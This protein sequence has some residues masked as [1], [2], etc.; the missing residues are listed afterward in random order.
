MI[1]EVLVHVIEVARDAEFVGRQLVALVGDVDLRQDRHDQGM[2]PRLYELHLVAG[3]LDPGGSGHDGVQEIG[4][5]L[6]SQRE[7]R[8]VEEEPVAVIREPAADL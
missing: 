6:R 8:I 4:C 2:L 3:V 5:D 1:E 7:K